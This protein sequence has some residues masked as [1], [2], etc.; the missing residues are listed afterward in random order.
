MVFIIWFVY[1]YSIIFSMTQTILNSFN[2]L[3][4][5][6]NIRGSLLFF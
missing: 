4:F 2:I 1:I 5:F 3:V 6:K